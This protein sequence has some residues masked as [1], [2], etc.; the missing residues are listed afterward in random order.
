MA[1]YISFVCILISFLP[2]RSYAD[3][4]TLTLESTGGQVS[5]PDYVYPYNFSID[6]SASTTPLMC[7][8]FANDIYFGESWTATIEPVTGSQQYEE[9]AYLFS[10][11]SAP[12]A[13][14]TAIAEAQWA[15][16][17]L[18][19][20]ND[21]NLLASEPSQYQNDVSLLL[22]QATLF[23]EDNPDASLYSEYQIYAPEAGSWPAGDGA[24]QYLI[25]ASTPEPSSLILVGSG[26]LGFAVFMYHRKRAI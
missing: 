14:Q 24:P 11:A 5:G 19:D 15:D 16:W 17:E 8:S 4:V 12:G 6:G 7:I 26:L 10:L 23:A 3:S 22:S 21:P 9:A 1:L 20:P 18:L 25:G 13:T 2:L